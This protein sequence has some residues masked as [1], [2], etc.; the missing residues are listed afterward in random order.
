MDARM[1]QHRIIPWVRRLLGLYALSFL[2]T[3][4][5]AHAYNPPFF[6]AIT[7]YVV[8]RLNAGAQTGTSVLVSAPSYL[9]ACRQ[10][11]GGAS[12]SIT[13]KF[14]SQYSWLCADSNGVNFGWV[15]LISP[16]CPAHSAQLGGKDFGS[17][18]A[19]AIPIYLTTPHQV[20]CRMI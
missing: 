4:T 7:K 17:I 1:W 12:P 6:P 19:V 3:G 13:L 2:V 16:I 18:A 11:Y 9:E 20:A 15:T 10:V 5:L 8:Y 14:W